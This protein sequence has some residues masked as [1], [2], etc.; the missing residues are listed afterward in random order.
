MTLWLTVANCGIRFVRED[1]QDREELLCL[2]DEESAGGESFDSGPRAGELIGQRTDRGTTGKIRAN[3]LGR[4]WEDQAGLNAGIE[5]A[6][7]IGKC[8]A[9]FFVRKRRYRG[10]HAIAREIDPF[11]KMGYLVSADA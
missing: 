1:L 11:Q 9:E 10:L 6:K 5:W 7:E 8:Y 3:E 4:N 2:A